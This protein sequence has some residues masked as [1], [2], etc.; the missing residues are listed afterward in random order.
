MAVLSWENWY[1]LIDRIGRRAGQYKRCFSTP[2]GEAVLKDLA[3]VCGANRVPF[4]ED[5]ARRDI[6]IGRLEVWRL[7]QNRLHM[8]AAE[9]AALGGYTNPEGTE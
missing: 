5:P 1:R 7:I 9:V 3:R 4:H 6:Q 2:D 8:S